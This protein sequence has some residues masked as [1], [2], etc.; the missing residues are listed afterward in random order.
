MIDLEQLRTQK[1]L[2]QQNIQ[3]GN[4]KSAEQLIKEYEKIY[5]DDFDIILAK[6][7]IHFFYGRYEDAEK[8]LRK[9]YTKFEYNYEVN[10][11]LGIVL[12][13]REKFKEAVYYLFR[14]SAIDE[15][16][17]EEIVAWLGEIPDDVYKEFEK[18]IIE[19]VK[20]EFLGNQKNF[21]ELIQAGKR[22]DL[23]YNDQ[24]Y[25]GIYDNYAPEKEGWHFETQKLLKNWYKF[26]TL[27]AKEGYKEKFSVT[28]KTILP[29][30][31]SQDG[32]FVN[33]K[34]NDKDNMMMKLIRNRYYYYT[35]NKGDDVFIQSTDKIIFGEKII[36]K[37][38]NTKPKLV[39]DIFID[40]FS[41]KFLRE[42]DFKDIAPN[43]YKFFSKGTICNNFY[44]TGDWTYSSLA[45]I[46]TGKYTTQHKVF[47][48]SRDTYN[49][50]SEE[51]YSEVFKKNGYFTTI[52]NGDW[53]SNPSIG[54][55][56]GVDRY[57][58]Q[59]AIR[60]MKCNDVLIET[61]EHLMAFKD[62]NNFMM[63]Y[64]PD[65]HDIVD[66]FQTGLST[67]IAT[68]ISGN[69]LEHKKTKT[70]VKAMNSSTIERYGLEI[71]RIDTYLGLLFDYIEKNYNDDEIVVSLFS[72]HGQS[73]IDAS[74]RYLDERRSNAVMMMRGRNIKSQNTEELISGI[75]FFPIILNAC[76][77][78]NYD[79]K[80]ANIPKCF[81]GSIERQFV[82]TECLYPDKP[83]SA[84]INDNVHKFFFD[85]KDACTSDGRIKIDYYDIA[86]INKK[87]EKEE[88][89]K[90]PEKVQ[91][92]TE[93]VF[94]HIK[95]LIII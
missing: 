67:Q 90:Y 82:Y 61:I 32:Q 33:I 16:K 39:L 52:I 40:G 17:A 55:L 51:L 73:F 58:Y 56:K 29:L 18:N 10:C 11:N 27:K 49:L 65:L 31:V 22:L 47:H 43:I 86:L 80:E 78:E 30:M 15:T 35:F 46:F 5:S 13:H 50:Y 45:S 36:I 88:K 44:V 20:N 62:L 87:T 19:K 63:I 79:L 23:I 21:P 69:V 7:I 70:V 42:N 3:N 26:E 53:R 72:D 4:I 2:I 9:L 38:D 34:V 74:T 94:N 68:S 84:V 37:R 24:Y 93:K 89:E 81:G 91:I 28:E 1:K 48:P 85:T 57:L 76:G 95:D 59:P 8:I 71:K 64:I 83:Y 12:L 66:E 54:Y 6:A 75:D 25:M 92:Y 41:Q 60:G 14:A 77:I